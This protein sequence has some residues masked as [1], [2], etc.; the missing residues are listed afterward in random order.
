MNGLPPDP[1]PRRALCSFPVWLVGS[2]F[3][4]L[5]VLLSGC[6]AV[7]V[8]VTDPF[9][10]DEA[11]VRLELRRGPPLM[12]LAPA[13]V[14]GSG[15]VTVAFDDWDTPDLPFQPGRLANELTVATADLDAGADDAPETITLTDVDVDVWLWHGAAEPD[16]VARSVHVRLSDLG[17][18]T[19]T[20]GA[21]TADTCSYSYGGGAPAF[22][23]L[24]VTGSAFSTAYTI[25]T[26][27][28]E[29]NRV[30]V[31][32]TVQAEPEDALDGRNL[33]VTLGAEKG[34]IG[35]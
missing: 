6:G 21:C 23:N 32:V 12:S 10:L 2:A 22:G 28:P 9:G 13:A 33:T 4:A 31:A 1:A 14:D 27:A 7:A 35:F 20:R 11:Q 18:I 15:Q 34:S 16:A 30:R 24:Q 8:P 3:A 5:I 26:Q 19:L 29:P 17:P 25:V